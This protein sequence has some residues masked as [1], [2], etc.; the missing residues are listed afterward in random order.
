VAITR[1]VMQAESAGLE[2]P[3]W[4]RPVIV[5]SIPWA[6][7]IHTVTA[8]LYS[9]LPGRSFWLTAL[10]APRF[11]A[12]A[13]AA[14]PA[15]LILLAM[16]L[17]RLT[18]FDPGPCAIPAL[19]LV[20]TYATA[21]SVFFMAVE[22]FT[23]LY[24]QIPEHVEHFR[25][26]FGGLDG[27]AGLVAWSWASVALVVFALALLLV[28]SRRRDEA[29]LA[30]AASLVFVSLWI[31]KGLML[32]VGGFVP[33]PLGAV[34]AYAPTAV[35]IGITA[36]IWAVGTGMVTVFFKIAAGTRQD[37]TA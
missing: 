22:A 12:S 6:V 30:V 15:L 26:L 1:A 8:F 18:R 24:S 37:R 20:V 19:A 32:V 13:F 28:P 3:R 5:L 31:E 9:G 16:L 14:G 27:H 11:L 17:R 25:Y 29:T 21:V 33:S 4:A 10:L 23:V 35:E 36:G 7:S 34:T 2:P